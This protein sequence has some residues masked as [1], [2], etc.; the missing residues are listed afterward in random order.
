MVLKTTL[1]KKVLNNYFLESFQKQPYVDL[2]QNR[3]SQK[4]SNIHRKTS[5]LE[6]FLVKWQALWP[7]TLF[8]RDFN[9]GIFLRILRNFYEQLFLQNTSGD[10]CQS[11]LLHQ[12]QYETV[13]TK[14]VC[15]SV[16]STLF[17]NTLL[18]IG[19]QKTKTCSKRSTAAKAICSDIRILTVQAGFCPLFYVYFNGMY[20]TFIKSP[21]GYIYQVASR[22]FPFSG[23]CS[24]KGQTRKISF[25]QEEIT[26]CTVLEIQVRSV[27]NT[28]VAK[29]CKN[30]KQNK[31]VLVVAFKAKAV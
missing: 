12:K 17:T 20:I 31:D 22:E 28:F 16:Q 30:F 13:S 6:S 10:I 2:L 5:V 18:L 19:L 7:A 27:N 8:K 14:Q 3:C 11:S 25:L 26:E 1:Q 21:R 15:R 29:I 23:N 24:E 9:P 4:F